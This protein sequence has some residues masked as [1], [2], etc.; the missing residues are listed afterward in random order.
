MPGKTNKSVA[1]RFKV[2][3]S[4]KVMYRRGPRSH[5][6][7]KKTPDAIRRIRK[8]QELA[9]PDAKKIVAYLPFN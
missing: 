9:R 7:A 4:G 1:K 5:F 2:T 3:R 6:R 8:Q